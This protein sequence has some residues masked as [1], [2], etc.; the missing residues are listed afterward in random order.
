MFCVGVDLFCCRPLFPTSL[1]VKDPDT[2]LEFAASHDATSIEELRGLSE[3][4]HRTQAKG[5]A[6]K[7]DIEVRSAASKS[8]LIS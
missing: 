3:Q 4:L 1:T 6:D 5:Q 2:F 7:A 8:I